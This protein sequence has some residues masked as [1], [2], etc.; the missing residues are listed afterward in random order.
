MAQ[1][2]FFFCSFLTL[3][4][5]TCAGGTGLLLRKICKSALKKNWQQKKKKK[6]K[7]KIRVYQNNIW[8]KWLW[9]NMLTDVC[10][11]HGHR[12]I[13][14]EINIRVSQFQQCSSLV[15]SWFV[16]IKPESLLLILCLSLITG[17]LSI[18]WLI[19]GQK[20]VSSHCGN[21]HLTPKPEILL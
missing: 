9:G 12:D 3:K 17:L 16:V 11:R 21:W 7:K 6:K 10:C 14:V 13:R 5:Q 20:C 8:L 15:Q 4:V 1:S 18:S 2:H 19:T